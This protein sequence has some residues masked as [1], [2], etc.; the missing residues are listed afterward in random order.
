MTANFVA[1]ESVRHVP[2]V[3]TK[4][5]NVGRELMNFPKMQRTTRAQMETGSVAAICV[6]VEL[7]NAAAMALVPMG[8]V[9]AVIPLLLRMLKTISATFSMTFG[10][11]IIPVPASSKAKPAKK[12]KD[13]WVTFAKSLRTS[14]HFFAWKKTPMN[15]LPTKMRASAA[16]RQTT[17]HPVTSAQVRAA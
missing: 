4:N 11:A 13:L 17:T 5:A 6:V 10:F 9:V 1:A 16:Q 12:G 2:A 3:S 8:S 14:M 7:A 15:T